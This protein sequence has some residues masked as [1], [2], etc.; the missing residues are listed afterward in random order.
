MGTKQAAMPKPRLIG[1]STS[2]R[3]RRTQ[4]SSPCVTTRT[5]RKER[6]GED[7]MVSSFELE[8]ELRQEKR[9]SLASGLAT[10][11]YLDVQYGCSHA[12][13]RGV[14]VLSPQAV[15]AESVCRVAFAGGTIAMFEESWMNNG[16]WISVKRQMKD[17]KQAGGKIEAET[18]TSKGLCTSE[19]DEAFGRAHPWEAG[20]G[21][22]RSGSRLDL[23]DLPGTQS[24][25][26]WV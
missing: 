17:K 5:R 26:A 21:Q 16:C 12:P 3:C 18:G 20:Q 25:K 1:T 10:L 8:L 7:D 2:R 24:R 15:P 14:W 19:P 9:D 23:G 13:A 22:V 4:M 6:R 11:G